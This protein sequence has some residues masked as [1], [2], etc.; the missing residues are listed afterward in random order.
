MTASNHV[1]PGMA[2]TREAAILSPAAEAVTW[3][4]ALDEDV[5]PRKGQRVVIYPTEMSQLE[6]V[7]ST[8]DPNIDSKDGHPIAYTQILQAARS[9]ENP[10]IF[11][12]EDS[13]QITSDPVISEKVP[14]WMNIAAVQGKRIRVLQKATLPKPESQSFSS[15]EVFSHRRFSGVQWH[16]ETT[17]SSIGCLAAHPREAELH[18]VVRCS[19]AHRW[20]QTNYREAKEGHQASIQFRGQGQRLLLRQYSISQIFS[21]VAARTRS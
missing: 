9:Y 5:S 2:N 15:A 11:L 1:L 17:V 12:R 3:K 18:A 4:H 13:E 14:G 20:D 6:Q 21:K 19:Q 10:P 8:G 7:L 16:S